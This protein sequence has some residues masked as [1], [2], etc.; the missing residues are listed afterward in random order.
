MKLQ[1]NFT[2]LFT[3]IVLGM[4][5]CKYFFYCL[6]SKIYK[7]EKPSKTRLLEHY[8]LRNGCGRKSLFCLFCQYYCSF[9]TL[10]RSHSTHDTGTQRVPSL[11][12]TMLHR[13]HCRNK[14]RIQSFKEMFMSEN[15]SFKAH[16]PLKG[17]GNTLVHLITL[18]QN[19]FRLILI[20]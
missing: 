8:T 13:K 11:T 19:F 17:V 15:C 1:R 10:S 4:I 9:K 14:K 2:S 3:F 16:L 5:L 7:F 20:L 6:R 12:M 18:S